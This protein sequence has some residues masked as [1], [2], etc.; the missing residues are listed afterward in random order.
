MKQTNKKAVAFLGSRISPF[1]VD[2][3]RTI[4]RTVA[5]LVE[6]GFIVPDQPEP[7]A[8][9]IA[10]AAKSYL[11]SCNLKDPEAVFNT[12]SGWDN[13]AWDHVLRNKAGFNTRQQI[14]KA[15]RLLAEEAGV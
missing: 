14:F 11:A 12:A 1:S 8:V 5:A 15:I 3:A 6:A 4:E 9:E 13:E 2:D 7:R 10:E